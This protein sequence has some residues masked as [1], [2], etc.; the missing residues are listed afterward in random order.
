MHHT[1]VII[2]VYNEEKVIKRVVR[3]MYKEGFKHIVVV[4]D[5]STDETARE[6]KK[7]NALLI[8]HSINRGK[9]A[10][11]KTGIETVRL[12]GYKNIVTFDGDGQHNPKDIHNL[13][14]YVYQGYDVVLGS[15]FLVRQPVP[16]I[17]RIANYSANILTHLL[18]GIKVTDSQSGLRAYS[19][20]ACLS[21]DTKSNR[22]EFDSEVI[23]EIVHK[24]LKYIEVPIHVRY[25]KYSQKKKNR[26]D[27]I[28]ALSSL[29]RI[30]LLS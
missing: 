8:Q 28:S 13:I 29:I 15:R 21:L 11:I 9:G 16:V 10:A 7:T 5:G 18:Y 3:K 19:K 6:V 25:T 22:Y 2:P 12:I 23:R 14:R 30:I 20:Q 24:H 17:K 1:V 27:L 4:D 26:Q